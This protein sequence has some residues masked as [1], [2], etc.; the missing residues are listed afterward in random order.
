MP[1]QAGELIVIYG[2]RE[3][4]RLR[5]EL[6]DVI[7]DGG[8]R[9]GK[10]R[11]DE[12]IYRPEVP[13]KPT[14]VI[15]EEGLVTLKRS[16]VRWMAPG[17]R[18]NPIN[19]LWCLPPFTPMCV[20]VGGQL[21]ATAKLDAAKGRVMEGIHDPAE[22]WRQAIANQ[23]TW[24]RVNQEVPALLEA[25]WSKGAP[26]EPGGPTLP[27]P[28]ARR[29]A[30]LDLW[31]TRADGPEGEMVAQVVADFLEH[32][33]Q[34]GPD[35]VTSDEQ[36]QANVRAAGVRRLDLSGLA[37]ARAVSPTAPDPG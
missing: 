8:Y 14:V 11:G 28:A 23:A 15:Q 2:E 7:Q 25:A 24:T 21:V 19:Q 4:Q 5:S 27:T 6:D 18:D 22:D 20:R 33:V 16:P 37:P 32:V 12:T 31:A 34:A 29:A 17:R 3:V 26:L 1:E 9:E 36:A 35:P 13:W 10:R 30:M